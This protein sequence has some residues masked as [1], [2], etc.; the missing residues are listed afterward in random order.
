VP[1]QAYVFLQPVFH[2]I[3]EREPSFL[4][5][6]PPNLNSKHTL[7][8]APDR[9]LEK[10]ICKKMICTRGSIDAAFLSQFR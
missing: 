8:E 5:T 2:V 1:Q 10:A 3:Y 6:F 7:E 9:A 4:S